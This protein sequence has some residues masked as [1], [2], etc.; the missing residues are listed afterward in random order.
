MS[1]SSAIAPVQIL[2][3]GLNFSPEA[4]GIGRYSGEMAQWL[5]S[6]GFDVHAITSP[7]YYPQ[8]HVQLP[9]LN[10]F[11]RESVGKLLVDRCPIWVPRHPTGLKRLL[12]RHSQLSAKRN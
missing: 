12:H 3:Y 5:S 1:P 10:R 11:S 6:R 8:W 4:V 9:A 7:P 2:L